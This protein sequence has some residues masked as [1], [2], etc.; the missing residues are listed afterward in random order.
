VIFITVG[1]SPFP[2]DRMLRAVARLPGQRLF[3]QHG[4]GE[5]P[6]DAARTVDFLSFAELIE[7]VDAADVVVSHAGAGTII[8]A[9]QAG[10]TPVL[11]PRLQRYGETVDDH[12]LELA[13]ALEAQSR[14]VVAWDSDRIAE[15]VAAAPARRSAEPER[16][17]PIH[18]ALQRAL[19][20]LDPVTG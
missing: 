3:V 9:L 1:A 5:P 11:V 4:P 15:A 12:Q 10:H 20:G 17:L 14:V 16:E 8:C 18:R 13:R 19:L 7:A 2:F 6:V